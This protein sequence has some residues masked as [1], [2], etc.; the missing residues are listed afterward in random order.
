MT[1]LADIMPAKPVVL[2]GMMGAGKT[3]IGRMLARQLNREF[4]DADIEIE[5]AARCSV[6]DI[7]RLYGE[8][9]FREGEER[10]IARVMEQPRSVIATGG[11]AFNSAKTRERVHR[12]GISV[13][14][15][16]ELN[17]L[18]E[19]VS[20][21]DDRPL[22]KSG[23]KREIMENL[24]R[25]RIPYYSEAELRIEIGDERP[26]ETLD[27][28]LLALETFLTGETGDRNGC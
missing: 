26:E 13:W 1:V 3:S 6:E 15:N 22:L 21:R 20:R 4:V 24:L 23:D 18:V 10:V 9:A 12:E 5:I 11:G 28:V 27:K 25:E 14:L 8:T 17:V 7:F 19:R 16:A 2:V